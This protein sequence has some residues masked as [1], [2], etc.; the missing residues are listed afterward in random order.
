MLQ[1]DTGCFCQRQDPAVIVEAPETKATGL[2]APARC[3]EAARSGESELS[4]KTM[5]LFVGAYGSEESLEGEG[6]KG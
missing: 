4:L 3:D 2:G 5:D 6:L 1:S